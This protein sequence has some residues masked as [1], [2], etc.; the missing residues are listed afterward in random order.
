[1]KV[2]ERLQ[3]NII[4]NKYLYTKLCKYK[5]PLPIELEFTLYKIKMFA[6]TIGSKNWTFIGL[7]ENLIKICS[8]TNQNK[9]CSQGIKYVLIK[10]IQNT[11][12]LKQIIL[13]VFGIFVKH[14]EYYPS[15]NNKH[16][17]IIM[18]IINTFYS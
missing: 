18:Y 9:N 10:T 14:S 12:L 17:I 15:L 3:Y 1:M 13:K 6:G 2:F 16:E 7:K 11:V 5:F 4:L 8:W